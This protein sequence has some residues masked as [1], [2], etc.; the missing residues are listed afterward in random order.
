MSDK[1]ERSLSEL[2]RISAQGRLQGVETHTL[3]MPDILDPF[4]E[5]PSIVQDVVNSMT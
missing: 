5:L 3:C 2:A 4:K 1:D